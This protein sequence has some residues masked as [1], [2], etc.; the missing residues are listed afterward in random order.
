M[1]EPV[2]L[3]LARAQCG[4]IAGDTSWDDL[5]NQFIPA[6]R[7]FVE[8]LTGHILLS[9]SLTS[10][11]AGF[12]QYLELPHRPV[13]TLTSIVY[14]DTDGGAQT[15]AGAVPALARYPVRIYPSEDDG[16]PAIQSNSSI[17]VTYTAGYAAGSEPKALLQAMLL[18]IGHWFANR[19]SVVIGVVST[20]V[21]M[22]TRAICDMHRPAL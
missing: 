1:A 4:I 10:T 16:W 9:R 21:E 13:T 15:Y 11:V 2:S 22:A 7:E 17:V 19:E 20:E 8:N 6:A 14:T 18:L 12:G 5:L 3:A